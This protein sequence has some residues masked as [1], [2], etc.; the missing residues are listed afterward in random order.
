MPTK[1]ATLYG[2]SDAA[3]AAGVA[4]STLRRYDRQGVISVI[5]DSTGKRLFT[6]EEIEKA[7]QH[8]ARSRRASD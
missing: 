4:E 6:P 7:R 3:R 8:R 2:I 5:R 1:Q